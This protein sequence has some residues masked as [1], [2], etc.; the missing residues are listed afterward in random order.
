MGSPL[1]RLAA[2]A[3]SNNHHYSPLPA[4]DAIR[5]ID[6]H[7]G[8]DEQVTFALD[9]TH[10]CR[11]AARY[12]ALSYCWGNATNTVQALCNGKPFSITPNL[13]AALRHLRKPDSSCRLWVDAVCVNQH[14]IAE[15]NQQV[16]IMRQIYAHALRVDVWLGPSDAD[17]AEATKLI[18]G[19]ALKCCLSTYGEGNRAWWIEQLKRENDPRRVLPTIAL[20]GLP[21]PSAHPW[22]A[23]KQYYNRAWFGR[24]WV[25]RE[26]QASLEVRVLCG[27]HA[28]EWE[29]VVLAACWMVYA[30]DL[31]VRSLFWDSRGIRAAETMRERLVTKRDVPFLFALDR[32]R[33]FNSTD[34]RD[35]VF[36][37]LRHAVI[38][39]P[40]IYAGPVEPWQL[41]REPALST[42]TGKSENVTRLGIQADY[43]MTTAQAYREV[44]VRS[45]QQYK[46]L[47]ALCYIVP[48]HAQASD[49]PSWVPR[50]DLKDAQARTAG[51][52]P[53]LYDASAGRTQSFLCYGQFD[54]S[55]RCPHRR[56]FRCFNDPANCTRQ[57]QQRPAV[58]R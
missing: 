19:I 39:A 21:H 14:D 57:C 15:R 27:G 38:H 25:I 10:H 33:Q 11:E 55:T 18:D 13:H 2:V 50:W 56:G 30:Q 58:S 47:E 34:P 20:T 4:G 1:N 37:M 41:A 32:V 7:P 52:P 54:L 51:G 5:T 35:K 40:H 44:T 31:A 43:R 48:M 9:I 26:V 3:E 24:V 12:H 6:L 42:L 23:M 28:I 16:S 45:I 8:E 53:Y 49:H 46:S 22:L 29:S 36:S 17:T